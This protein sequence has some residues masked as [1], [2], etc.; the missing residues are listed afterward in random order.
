MRKKL[1]VIDGH[2]L[3]Y[4]AYFAIRPLSDS[5]GRMT[6]A[7]YGFVQM[8][9]KLLKEEKP[10]YLAVAFDTGR[11]TFRHRIFSEYKA[12]RAKMP[13]DM[14]V[15]MELIRE[16]VRAFGFPIVEAEGYEADDCMGALAKSLSEEVDVVLVTGDKDV[17]QLVED[18]RIRVIA[19]QKGISEIITYDEVKVKERFGVPPPLV[20][21]VLALAGDPSDNIPG[22]KGIGEKTAIELIKRFGSLEGL[23]ENLDKVEGR[24]AK[25][26]MEDRENAFLSR[27]LVRIK[28]DIRVGLELEKA[29]VRDKVPREAVELLKDLEFRRVL[30]ELESMGLIERARARVGGDGGGYR[31]LRDAKDVEEILP[32]ML[33]AKEMG[34][35]FHLDGN[36]PMRSRISS[37]SISPSPGE[38][39][40][41]WLGDDNRILSILRPVFEEDGIEKIG[42]NLK[43]L[44]I[45]LRRS[46]IEL[47]GP[48][49]DSMVASYLVD[50]TRGKYELDEIIEREMGL[51][52]SAIEG[53]SNR[54]CRRAE[55][56]LGLK[57]TMLKKLS[58]LGLEDLQRKVEMPLVFVLADMEINGV[59]VDVDY[60]RDMSK[61]LEDRL[62]DLTTRIYR[63]AGTSFNINSPKQLAHVLFE[64][65]MLPPIKKTKTGYSTSED[66][67]LKLAGMHECPA[68]ILEY[69]ELAK[70][71]STY[72]DALPDMV[73]P[74]TG[75]IHTSFN[76]TVTATGRLSSSS[77]NLQNIPVRTELG[78]KIRKAFIPEEGHLFVGADY[79]QIELR[80]LAHIS[81]DENLRMAFERGEDIHARTAS[82]VFG[83]DP[84]EVTPDMRRV[85]K[86]VNFGIVY[87]MSAYGLSQ[88]LG[89]EVEEAQRYINSYFSTYPGVKRYTEEII[90]SARERKYV[91][92]LLGRRRPIPDIDSPNANLRQF[93]ERTAINTPI[94][95]TAA[96][97]I[98]IAMVDI[99]REIKGRGLRAKMIIQVHDELI[100]ELP[101][102]EVEEFVGLIK[103]I[104]E[105]ALDLSVPIKVDISVGNTWADLG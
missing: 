38:A 20:V 59:K 79:S 7:I 51:D 84:G 39:Y 101:K 58:D 46:G 25:R 47:K 26:L 30:E 6:N 64:K 22:V 95:G 48:I 49:F 69:R 13:E 70:L 89:I 24:I 1:I 17:L 83:V 9:L 82:Q 66:V 63:A 88:D 99:W 12:N 32:R 14:R 23:Y 73:N 3:S 94:Q 62:A 35:D 16:M 27:E 71:K 105:G 98:K 76:Q 41:I 50:P 37:I 36:E 78:R 43:H 52:I 11:P 19:P 104:M 55:A 56:L 60:L 2:A 90:A 68:L 57:E 91:T 5:K 8:L 67:L 33:K 72:V 54:S 77:P 31:V 45:A 81:G 4:R 103:P 93:A 29:A 44:I 96:D 28:T 34:L 40:N 92:T 10:D 21:E 102:E 100:F 87:G 74:E 80:I 85:A 75:R 53:F 15:Q 65:L 97:L 86:V 18:G 42:H 61:E